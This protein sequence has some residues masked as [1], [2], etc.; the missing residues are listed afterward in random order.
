MALFSLKL[1][2]VLSTVGGKAIS[3]FFWGV[4]GMNSRLLL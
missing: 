2:L 1:G 3:F 4:G